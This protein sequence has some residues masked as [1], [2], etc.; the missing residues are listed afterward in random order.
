METIA[1]VVMVDVNITRNGVAPVMPV[2]EVVPKSTHRSVTYIATGHGS[3]G[4]G[5]SDQ[6]ASDSPKSSSKSKDGLQK[7]A[8]T[9][10]TN[11]LAPISHSGTKNSDSKK[12]Q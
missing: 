6:V 9:P 8:V 11:N 1:K 10:R 2:K 4:I 3:D 7:K 5:S 12:L